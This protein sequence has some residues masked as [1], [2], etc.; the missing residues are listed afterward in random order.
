MA[1]P[2]PTFPAAPGP[3]IGS[4]P[5]TPTASRGELRPHSGQ[6][7]HRSQ[8]QAASWDEWPPDDGGCPVLVIGEERR[9]EPGLWRV[10]LVWTT[11]A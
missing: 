11:G 6:G 3:P 8:G 10:A 9:M 1:P 7:R 2:N 5:F 4:S